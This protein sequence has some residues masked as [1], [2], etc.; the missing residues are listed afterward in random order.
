M[1][2]LSALRGETYTMLGGL[3]EFAGFGLA[4]KLVDAD[5]EG[6]EG[7]AGAGG[8]GDERRLAG[9]DAGPAPGLGVGGV[10]ETALEPGAH[11]R[12][13]RP[14]RVASRRG[15]GGYGVTLEHPCG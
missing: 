10:R 13:E 14:E 12:V 8:G 3:L 11:D 15:C 7:L 5:E 1:S 2:L 6:G 9:V 4:D